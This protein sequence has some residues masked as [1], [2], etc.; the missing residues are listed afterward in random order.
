MGLGSSNKIPV[1]SLSLSLSLSPGGA[2]IHT[3]ELNFVFEPIDSRNSVYFGLLPL[4]C[5][6]A[7]G[8]MFADIR[9]L[10]ELT[11]G[12][13]NAIPGWEVTWEPQV[14]AL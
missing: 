11:D 14:G 2:A 1:P 9:Q 6:L 3:G 7:E 12:T 8:T 13:C 4:L 10:V 5:S